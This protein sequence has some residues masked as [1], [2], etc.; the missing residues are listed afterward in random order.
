[1]LRCPRC[2]SHMEKAIAF[3]GGESEFWLECSSCNTF[4]NTYTPQ[5][6]Q[7]AVHKDTHRYI[8]NFG[9]YGTGKTLVSREEVIKHCLLTDNANV[10]IGA[11]VAS[12]YEQTIKR[13]LEADI[14]AA[15]IKDYSAQKSYMDWINGARIM[16]RPFDDPDKLRSYNLTMFVIVEASEVKPESFIQLRSR[17]RN[18]NATVPKL[19]KNGDPMYITDEKGRQ[20]PL[21]MADWRRGIIESN[22]GAGWIRENVLY[23]ASEIHTHGE[24]VD[25]YS[26][27]DNQKDPS[28]SVHVAS[29]DVNKYLPPTFVAELTK[30]RPMWWIKRYIYS[31]FSYAEG[32]VYPNASNCVVEPYEIQKHWL[33][34]AAFDYGLSDD[35]VFLWLAVDQERG[36]VIIYKEART[37]NRD[38]AALAQVFKNNSSDI[39]LGGWLGPPLID[40]KSG[41]KRDFNK[42]T[43]IDLMS[44]Q[45]IYFKPGH[46]NR[47]ARVF[48]LNTYIEQG[49]LEIFNTCEGLVKEIK[50]LKFKEMVGS[51]GQ[52]SNKPEDKDD[53]GVC[54][55]EWLAMELPAEPTNLV[56]GVYDKFGRNVTNLVA[57]QRNHLPYALQDEPDA[58]YSSNAADTAYGIEQIAYDF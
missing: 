16:Y 35:S 38:V 9:G 41:G 57:E 24:I 27:P 50:N 54:A 8:G 11:N 13:E 31:S 5:K 14:P 48:R 7:S 43:L 56:R 19:D 2:G 42:R 33:R 32:L 21:L 49:V 30:N 10:L 37:K 3:N 52:R 6:H 34:L 40:P 36:K 1:M 53:H 29:T 47:D 12:Q 18:R 28:I 58:A 23:N 17:L 44:E 46:V 20:V 45:G 15:F 55:L 26:V 4:V 25:K 22:P 39:P 51:D